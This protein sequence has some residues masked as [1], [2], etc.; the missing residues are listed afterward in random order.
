MKLSFET[1]KICLSFT[2]FTFKKLKLA[3]IFYWFRQRVLKYFT[4]RTL[5]YA[6]FC[7]QYTLDMFLVLV[8]LCMIVNF[9]LICILNIHLFRKL[10][11]LSNS[12]HCLSL[13]DNI[14]LGWLLN[15]VISRFWLHSGCSQTTLT[16]RG[17]YLC[18]PKLVCKI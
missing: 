1:W 14:A 12:I 16:R 15:S 2:L 5:K 10:V 11:F 6:Q 17:G 9:T 8:W 13:L 18:N 3:T 7:N 4:I